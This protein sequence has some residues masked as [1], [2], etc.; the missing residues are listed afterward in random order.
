MPEDVSDSELVRFRGK[1]AHKTGLPK[2]HRGTSSKRPPEAMA[3]K[4]MK[5]RKQRISRS[6]VLGAQ[7]CKAESAR[8]EYRSRHDESHNSSSLRGGRGRWWYMN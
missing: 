5:A 1:I 4:G 2:H 6:D 8:Q 7:L 3:E